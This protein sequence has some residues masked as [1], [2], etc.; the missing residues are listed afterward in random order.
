MRRRQAAVKIVGSD[1]GP[2]LNDLDAAQLALF[3][4]PNSLPPAIRYARG[5]VWVP[6]ELV[7]LLG[8]A[9]LWRGPTGIQVHDLGC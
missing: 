3:Q 4:G 7:A 5:R 8:T 2:I 6:T 1:M 9:G